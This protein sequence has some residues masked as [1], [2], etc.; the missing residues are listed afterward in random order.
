MRTL[1][2]V[3]SGV[4]RRIGTW[5]LRLVGSRLRAEILEKLTEESIQTTAI[6]GACIQFYAPSP[7]LISRA[8][9]VLTKET[10]TIQW[11][12]GFEQGTVFWDIGANVGV[13]SL[14]AAIRNPGFVV[15]FEP[16]AANF[17]VLSRNIQLNR[18]DQ[19]ISAYCVAFSGRTQLGTLNIASPSMGASL[20]QFGEPGETSRYW[21]G[22]AGATHGMVGFTIDEFIKQFDPPFPNYLKIDVDGLEIAIL[23]GARRTLCDPRMRSLLVELSLNRRHEHDAA[24]KLLEEAGFH[25]VSRGADQGNQNESA[26]NHI[27]QKATWV[28]RVQPFEITDAMPNLRS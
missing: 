22:T 13:F 17:H 6:P 20:S 10:D 14:Y 1:N 26:A 12:D 18:L 8:A 5:P 27:F 11:I 19:Q 23:E 15:S 28:E 24:V 9:S 25:F 4:A 3:G 2:K 16:L 7:L 21:E